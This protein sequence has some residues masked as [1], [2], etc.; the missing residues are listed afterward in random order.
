M[1]TIGERIAQLRDRRGMTQSELG[2]AI[3]E[4]KQTIY[5]YEHGIVTNIPLAKVEAIARVLRC[6]PAILTGWETPEVIVPPVDPDE[7]EREAFRVL[8]FQLPP[9]MR[10]LCYNALK[11]VVDEYTRQQADEAERIHLEE[12]LKASFEE[13]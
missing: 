3:G 9:A 12:A 2:D 8:L 5:K 7:E 10:R 13:E 1:S 4:T 11:G 6:P